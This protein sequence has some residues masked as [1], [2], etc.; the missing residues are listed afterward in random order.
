ML[1]R[2]GRRAQLRHA[3]RDVVAGQR[4]VT[5]DEIGFV[6][7]HGLE[8]GLADGHGIGV[9]QRLDAVGA[10]VARAALDGVELH[11]HALPHQLEH[12]FG[13]AADLLHAAMTG[14]VITD[15][16][17]RGL[18]V[19]LE[20]AV[21]VARHQVLEGVE[22]RRLDG[23]RVGVIGK[24]Q[25]QLLLEHQRAAGNGAQDG[26]ALFGVTRQHRDVGAPAFLNRVQ[27]AKLKARH[28]AA[29][30][31]LDDLV[32]DLVVVQ[33]LDEVGADAGLVVVDIA[34][35]KDCHLARFALAVDGHV[36]GVV[37]H[38]APTKALFGHVRHPDLGVHAQQLVHGLAHGLGGVDRVDHV[39]DDGNTRKL[40]VHVGA[41]Q[42]LL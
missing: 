23:L 38:A 35:G 24:H 28:A 10:G 18:E 21:L 20:Q 27:V 22:H 9:M 42:Q 36:G 17:Q 41:G 1:Q 6:L 33:Q 32:G 15:A 13:L 16:A 2:L 31:F 5:A 39:D 34:G 3:L 26:P 25:R 30:L 14:D 29:L 4:A 40:A 12:F 19:G 11:L 7:G 8:H 37:H